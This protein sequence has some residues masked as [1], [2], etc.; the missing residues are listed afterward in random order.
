MSKLDSVAR[1]QYGKETDMCFVFR[2]GKYQCCKFIEGVDEASDIAKKLVTLA[3]NLEKA[4]I[5]H[6]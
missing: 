5:Y 3:D 6:E 2:N 4:A 1:Q